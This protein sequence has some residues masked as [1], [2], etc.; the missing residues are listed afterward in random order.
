M[1]GEGRGEGFGRGFRWLEWESACRVGLKVFC[2]LTGI[3]SAEPL[4]T[5]A[6]RRGGSKDDE[7]EDQQYT[8]DGIRR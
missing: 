8:S 7:L 3:V 2:Q 6:C 4:T 5:I 1:K